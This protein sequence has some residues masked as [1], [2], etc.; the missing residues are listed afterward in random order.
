MKKTILTAVI[1]LMA[2]LT[3]SQD[4]AIDENIAYESAI[5]DVTS[6]EKGVL[7]PRMKRYPGKASFR[8]GGVTGTNWDKNSTGIYSLAMGNNGKAKG[9]DAIEL[10]YNAT[11]SGNYSTAMEIATMQQLLPGTITSPERGWECGEPLVDARDGQS[12]ET[13]KIGSQC[14]MAENLNI[15]TRIDG[16]NNQT[17]NGIIEKYCYNDSEAQCDVY[18]G[19]YQWNEMM[20]NSTTPGEQGICPAGWHI[21]TDDE[22]CILE[23]ELDLTISCSSTNWRGV[24]GGGKLKEAGTTHWLTPNTGATNSSG[25]TALPGGSRGSS[26]S[27]SLLTNYG[28]WWSSS[29]ASSNA[30]YRSLFYGSAQVRRHTNAKTWGYSVRCLKDESASATIPTVSTGAITEITS[31]TAISGGNVTDDG[32]ADVT[33]RGVCW[34]TS[35]IPTIADNVTTDGTGTGEFT[36]YINWLTPETT[37]YVRAYATNSVGTAYGG[38]LS[39]TTDVAGAIEWCLPFTDPRNEQTYQTV[40]IGTQCW[41]AENLNIG[42]MKLGNFEQLDD[43]IIEKYCYDDI[44]ANCVVY[45]GLYQWNEMMHY[46][47]TP[48]VQGICPG[49]WHIP[50]DDEWCIL[51]QE[52]DPTI[53]CS[54]SGWRGLDG[55]GK[56]KKTGTAQWNAPN[57]GAT[58]S[59][60]FTALPGGY[61]D[62]LGAFDNLGDW[63][64]WWSSSQIGG[65]TA[66]NRYLNAGSILVGRMDNSKLNGFSVRCVKNTGMVEVPVDLPLDG[67]TVGSG[68]E[69]CYN[70]SQSITV[71]NF[72][73]QSGGQATFIAGA[74]GSIVLLPETRVHHDGYLHA[75]I[76][77]D[78]TYCT[79]PSSMLNSD[80]EPGE[81]E[82]QD[83]I[84]EKINSELV[85]YPNPTR[86]FFT[87][88][89]SMFK[90]EDEVLIEVFSMHGEAV[91]RG[92]IQGSGLSEINLSGK[93]PGLYIIRLVSGKKVMTGKILKL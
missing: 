14:W 10:G 83:I 93:Q 18:G 65:G 17:N 21:P 24:D 59:S 52:I 32:G 34:S 23:Q 66:W 37:Y 70:A 80:S 29:Q 13:V 73:V 63:G 61:R 15:G 82:I 44:E 87:I 68:Q 74:S 7:I 91:Y 3:F 51:E 53:D 54:S 48:G 42:T 25:F 12:Y 22:W 38:E 50:T 41:M 79:N 81:T 26:G 47:T 90:A 89:L 56:L 62:F 78:E 11:S 36:S 67:V 27:F 76:T 28:Y 58:N 88:D 57:T 1:L 84:S 33:A 9:S 72:T 69:N 92:Q 43:G 2:T 40:Q 77:L 60:G 55:G 4:I 8:P 5:P 35:Q 64:Y 46:S 71:Q 45:G 75:Y 39:F 30:W 49:G 16:G 6:N 19:L 86:G 31:T 85:Y 20:A